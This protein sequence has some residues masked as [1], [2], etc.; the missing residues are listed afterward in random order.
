MKRLI[1]LLTIMLLAAGC[2]Q[3]ADEPGSMAT[4]TPSQQAGA[5]A[6]PQSAAQTGAAQADIKNYFGPLP[7]FSTEDIYGE[8]VDNGILANS[9]LTMVNYWATWCGPCRAEMPDLGELSKSMPEGSQ[10][11]SVCLDGYEAKSDAVQIAEEAGAEY[12]H[13]LPDEAL[14]KYSEQIVGIPTTIFYDAEGNQV[15]EPLL[16]AYPGEVYRQTIEELLKTL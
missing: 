7:Q 15:G 3:A 10:I 4:T 6:A 5:P 14:M 13:M 11:I 9:K 1:P 16:A 12:I 8:K 2:S